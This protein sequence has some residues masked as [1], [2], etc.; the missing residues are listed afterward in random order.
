MKKLTL[1]VAGAAIA[2]AAYA[3]TEHQVEQKGKTFTV[4]NLKVKVGDIVDFK[5]VDP[6]NHN[7]F[8]LSD[9][10]NFDLG[11]FG[12]GGSKKVIF[13]KPGTVEVECAI[14]PDMKMVVEV[15]K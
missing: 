13:D 6:F 15:G 4:K 10:K 2:G 3:A 5:N 11:S 8:S 7:V 9:A 12:Q 14:H 1:F